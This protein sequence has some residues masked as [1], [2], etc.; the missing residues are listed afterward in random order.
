MTVCYLGRKPER[1]REREQG[2][3]SLGL[4]REQTVA[5]EQDRPHTERSGALDVVLVGVPDHGRLRGRDAQHPER[6]LE[7]RGMR[8]DVPVQPRSHH[9][10][11]VQAVVRDELVEISL[12][13][14]DEP[15]LQAVS[16]ELVEHGDR[17]V[18][19]GEVLV[20]LPRS[21][22]VGRALPGAVC[23]SAHAA[24]DVLGERDP[25]LVVVH[26]LA[27][28][29]QLGDRRRPSGVVALGCEHEP[30]PLPHAA[31]SLR[32]ELRPGSKEGEVDIEQHCAKHE[33]RIALESLRFARSGCGAAW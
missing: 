19:E 26:Q 12:A 31:V 33:P 23:V 14:R 8:L 15:D 7:D 11:D 10:V 1:G 17:I 9:R 4:V 13:V 16:P 20:L 28:A 21:D 27:L 32:P 2:V 22:H 18:V 5:V 29:L 30:V 6:G 25:D 3:D 24:N